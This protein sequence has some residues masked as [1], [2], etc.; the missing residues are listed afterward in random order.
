M[1]EQRRAIGRFADDVAGHPSR[2]Q[3]AQG[4]ERGTGG[5]VGD[6]FGKDGVD[7]HIYHAAGRALLGADFLALSVEELVGNLAQTLEDVG[8]ENVSDQAVAVADELVK[9]LFGVLYGHRR[10]SHWSIGYRY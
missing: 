6:E 4:F 2:A 10:R 7:S 3:K 8:V 1:P 9:V 5:R